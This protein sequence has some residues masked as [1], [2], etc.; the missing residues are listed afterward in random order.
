MSRSWE[1]EE[2][3][4]NAKPVYINGMNQKVETQRYEFPKSNKILLL[5]ISL[6]DFEKISVSPVAICIL[7]TFKV[8]SEDG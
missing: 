1:G 6:N 3:R 8:V 4:E 7:N 5:Y 2:S